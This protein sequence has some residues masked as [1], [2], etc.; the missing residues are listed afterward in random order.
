LVRVRPDIFSFLPVLKRYSK[1]R[2]QS[3]PSLPSYRHQPGF[4]RVLLLS[5][6]APSARKIAAVFVNQLDYI[7][8][9]ISEP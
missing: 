1:F 5:V 8:T 2:A 6:A 7:T 4:D 3:H 9:F